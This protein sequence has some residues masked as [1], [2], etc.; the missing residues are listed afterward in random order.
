VFL[1]HLNAPEVSDKIHVVYNL[2]I[3]ELASAKLKKELSNAL[4][5][6]YVVT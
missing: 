3:S 1:R 2:L 4:T 5:I 6:L